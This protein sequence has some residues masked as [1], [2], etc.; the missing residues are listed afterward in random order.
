[1]P[2]TRPDDVPVTPKGRETRERLLDA[3]EVVAARHGLAGLSVAAVTSQAG[4]AKGTFYVHFTDR[5]AFI[6]AIERRFYDR[7]GEQVLA[8]VASLDPGHDFLVAAVEAYLDAC[9]ANHAVK[10]LI[11]ESRAHAERGAFFAEL[12]DRFEALVAPSMEAIGMTP[13]GVHVRLLIALASETVLIEL[14]S[15]SR[16]DAARDTVRAMLRSA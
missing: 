16:V 6:A 3:G 12:L 15:G 13:V 7:V 14:D 2:A 11:L 5:A 8:A 9:L 4:V 1:M 10:A